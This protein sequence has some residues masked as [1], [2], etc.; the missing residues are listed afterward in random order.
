MDKVNTSQYAFLVEN[1]KK[2]VYKIARRFKTNPFDF[3]DLV[4]AGLMGLYRAACRFDI[5]KGVKF[6]TYAT[7]FIIGSIKDELSKKSLI[8]NYNYMNSLENLPN[9]DATDKIIYENYGSVI[10][11]EDL[12]DIEGNYLNID[13][14]DFDSLEKKILKLRL[15]NHATQMEIA[16]EL[17]LSQSKVSRIL[18]RMREKVDIT[19]W[20][21]NYLQVFLYIIG[22]T[23]NNNTKGEGYG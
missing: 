6:S 13:N 23:T 16:K 12:N 2:L 21:C 17:S 20:T 10:L 5:T 3:D 8:K 14:F 18:K 9:K 15:V 11:K 22:N 4:Q 7:H 19:K 1:N